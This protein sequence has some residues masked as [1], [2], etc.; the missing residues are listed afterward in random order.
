MTPAFA[1]FDGFCPVNQ[2]ECG[3]KGETAYAPSGKTV[4]K[5]TPSLPANPALTAGTLK[6]GTG[7]RSGPEEFVKEKSRKRRKG[8]EGVAQRG[9]PKKVARSSSIGSGRHLEWGGRNSG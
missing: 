8:R 7:S 4:E 2:G 9:G 1:S 5:A 6:D 3:K